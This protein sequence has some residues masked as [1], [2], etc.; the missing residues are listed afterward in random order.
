[1]SEIDVRAKLAEVEAEEAEDTPTP[2]EEPQYTEKELE[3][4]D[5]GWN[6]EGKDKD[7]NTLNADEYMARKPLF[8]KIHNMRGEMDEMK[9]LLKELK[10]DQKKMAK[11]FIKENK[12]LIDQLKDEKEKALDNLD[13][14][15]VRR[16]DSEIEK[17]VETTKTTVE[18]NTE[19]RQYDNTE[20]KG[21][22]IN[23]LKANSWYDQQPGLKSAADIIGQ[24]YSATHQGASPTEIYAH[25]EA[26]IKREFADR[27]EDKPN[28]SKVST[29]TRRA[30]SN[31]K[32][33][34]VQ[35]SD[36]DPEEQRVVTVMANAVGKSVDDYM[37]TYKLED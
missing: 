22:Y 5:A 1:M 33:K 35:L 10:G 26:E 37:K 18:D 31:T 6:P 34:G 19:V 17:V 15:E 16:L 32:K 7:G 13:T 21:A 12:G 8:N 25:I 27:F 20:W 11:S 28:N 4:L 23:F 9:A 3:A 24:E 2:V 36:L 29:S 30:A 14:E